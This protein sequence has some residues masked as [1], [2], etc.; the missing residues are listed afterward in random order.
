[1]E[2]PSVGPG[3]ETEGLA[4]LRHGPSAMAIKD[5]VNAAAREPRC[6]HGFIMV[7]HPLS[8]CLEAFWGLEQPL[9]LTLDQMWTPYTDTEMHILYA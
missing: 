6:L 3:S 5:A 4:K 2:N 1:M 9:G 7:Y 8:A